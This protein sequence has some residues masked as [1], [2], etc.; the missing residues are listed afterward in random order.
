MNNPTYTFVSIS[1][2][3]EGKM[4]ELIRITKSPTEKMDQKTDG[5]IARQVSVDRDRNTVVVWATFDNKATL[6]DYLETQQGQDDHGE[7]EDMESIVDTFLMY[8]LEP[9]NGRVL[10]KS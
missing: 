1:T 7:H 5:L 9:L 2:P 3:K 4:D 6:Y 10:P 8:D